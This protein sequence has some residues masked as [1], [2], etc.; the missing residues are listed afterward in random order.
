MTR[1][2]VA[3]ATL[4]TLAAWQ[5][6]ASA[7]ML[8][9]WW[10]TA[11]VETVAPDGGSV[12]IN[13]SSSDLVGDYWFD[14]TN[15]LA[16]TATNVW[17]RSGNGNHLTSAGTAAPTVAG[18]GTFF[19][20]GTND[21]MNVP[22]GVSNAFS[23]FIWYRANAYAN[24]K[25]VYWQGDSKGAALT[26]ALFF[27][28]ARLSAAGPNWPVY[29]NT[30]IIA[31]PSAGLTNL[32]PGII[33]SNVLNRITGVAITATTNDA[34]LFIDGTQA[35]SDVTCS[36]GYL[37]GTDKHRGLGGIYDAPTVYPFAGSIAEVKIY[38][39]A[40]ESNVV[41]ALGTNRIV[42]GPR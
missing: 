16:D 27:N 18:D 9:A 38:R 31:G 28:A 33:A 36:F 40:L 8:A 34:R 39:V 42:N 12:W 41:T 14:S 7:D 35:M 4:V 6:R 13:P 20:D 5:A 1:L 30:T 32:N 3:L 17:D 21:A 10:A 19:F 15:A 23:I 26:N 2:A 11:P 24:G 25:I 29:S 37:T 22:V